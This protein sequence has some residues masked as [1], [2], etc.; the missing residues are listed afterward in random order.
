M[1]N[2][3]A[4]VGYEGYYEVSDLG[5]VRSL[6]RYIGKRFYEGR[7][8]STHFTKFGYERVE[9][10]KNNKAV[11]YTVHSLVAKAFIIKPESDEVLDVCHGPN[12]KKD[13]SIGNLRWDTKSNNE[14][15]KQRDG[16]NPLVN[17]TH[18]SNGH[19]Y[20]GSNL[21]S[22]VGKNGRM[23]RGCLSCDRAFAKYSNAKKRGVILDKTLFKQVAD[24][25]YK[26]LLLTEGD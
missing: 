26:E 23:T 16:T 2:W 13:N 15:D 20:S 21:R 8:I 4:I 17:K 7:L 18:C 5:R 12:G 24:A 19:P 11:K 9:L 10:N 1:E 6:D 3:K 25:Y 22:R 14:L